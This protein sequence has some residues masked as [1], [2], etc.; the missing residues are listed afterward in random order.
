MTSA[1]PNGANMQ[2]DDPHQDG[3][4]AGARSAG[5]SVDVSADDSGA[6]D[7]G[8]DAAERRSGRSKKLEAQLRGAVGRAI[9]DYGMIEDGDRVM[10]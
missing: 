4:A 3:M 6:T 2:L 9:V 8:A 5:D 7:V 1:A 10:V